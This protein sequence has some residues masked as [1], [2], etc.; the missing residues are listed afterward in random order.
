MLWGNV[1]VVKFVVENH[2]MMM[3]LRF[4]CPLSNILVGGSLMDESVVLIQM[5]TSMEFCSATQLHSFVKYLGNCCE[6]E[7]L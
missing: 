2:L 6:R 1:V 7:L 4:S 3:I 5:H